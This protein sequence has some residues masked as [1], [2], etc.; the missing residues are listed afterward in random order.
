MGSGNMRSV[1]PITGQRG[2][3]DTVPQGKAADLERLEEC[4]SLWRNAHY[5]V[6]SRIREEW[7]VL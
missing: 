4:G 3:D 6:P 7:S 2:E 1:S 5:A